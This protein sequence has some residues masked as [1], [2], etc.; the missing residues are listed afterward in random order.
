MNVT[1][2][3]RTIVLT[4]E[5]ISLYEQ[6]TKLQQGV[7]LNTLRGMKPADAHRDAGG[8]C[9]NEERRRA[10]G[11]QILSNPVVTSAIVGASR[12]DQLREPMEALDV[13]LGPGEMAAC[14]K[15]WAELQGRE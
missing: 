12:A 14:D 2:G 3:D 8:T 15:V 11:D 1:I 6:L 10:L 9:K 7:A 5:Q 4:D 13:T